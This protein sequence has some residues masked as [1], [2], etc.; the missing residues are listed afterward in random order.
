MNNANALASGAT[1]LGDLLT[2]F[3]HGEPTP[4][5]VQTLTLTGLRR[6][7]TYRLTFFVSSWGGAPLAASSSR[8]ASGSE[9]KSSVFFSSP[10]M[11]MD[12]SHYNRILKK[13]SD[14]DPGQ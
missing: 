1:G 7:Y 9:A 11:S 2:D 12:P 14:I 10:F 6:P 4:P 13:Y 3:Y 8:S 5:G